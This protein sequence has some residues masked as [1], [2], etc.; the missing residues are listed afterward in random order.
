M[1]KRKVFIKLGF[2]IIAIIIGISATFWISEVQ[3]DLENQ[4]KEIKLLK[5]IQINVHNIDKY[6]NNRIDLLKVENDLM[7]YISSNWK[8]LNIDSLVNVLKD[9][10]YIK[11][12]HN[13]FLDYREFHPPISE[14][15]AIIDDG[16]LGLIKNEKIRLTL[17]TLLDD[18]LDFLLQNVK[19]EI[20]LQQAFRE[21]LISEK[22][23]KIVSALKTS[24]FEMENRIKGESGY[25]NKISQ[26]LKAITELKSAENY[27]NLK[28]RQ[29]YWVM[30]FMNNFKSSL[31]EISDLVNSELD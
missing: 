7:D 11:S 4:E 8:G 19:S 31:T 21:N 18:R 10:K 23:E 22:N 12:F 28:I 2:E 16:S 14:L 13:I 20:Q 9:G 24:Y 29:R 27:L 3:K 15:K 5:T 30:F 17:T 26:E 25:H 1:I 6:T